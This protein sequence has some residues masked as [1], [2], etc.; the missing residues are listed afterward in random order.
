MA[1]TSPSKPDISPT[2][3][4]TRRALIEA[5]E[6]LFAER[7]MEA[8]SIDEIALAANIA[9]GSFYNHFSDR[10]D[11]ADAIVQRLQDEFEAQ[12]ARANDGIDDP[13]QRVIRGLCIML[14]CGLEQPGRLHAVI[15]LSES[16]I[17]LDSPLNLSL[18]GTIAEGLRRGR[19]K[20]LS[21]DTA[22]LVIIGIINAT[23]SHTLKSKDAARDI[24]RDAGAAL[25]RALG[26]HAKE[27]RSLAQSASDALLA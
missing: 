3:A 7:V 12:L 11:L 2:R 23:V 6:A 1:K 13:A 8:V 15:R 18:S 16:R 5:G 21:A 19:F 27:A 10:Q 17:R 20:A 9:K 22:N 25:L 4:R 24:A 14:R 26:L